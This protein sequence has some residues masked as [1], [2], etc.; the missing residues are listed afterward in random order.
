[1]NKSNKYFKFSKCIFSAGTLGILISISYI[2][3]GGG[4]NPI[5]TVVGFI[6]PFMSIILGLIFAF[7]GFFT[8]D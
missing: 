2:L 1:M 7:I 8:K 3:D 5:V 6:L 4:Y